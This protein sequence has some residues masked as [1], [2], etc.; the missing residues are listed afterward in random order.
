[1]ARA[2]S[3]ARESLDM[4]K[5]HSAGQAWKIWMAEVHVAVLCRLQGKDAE[6]EA[7][8][9]E[10]R[11]IAPKPGSPRY[12][13]TA[14]SCERAAAWLTKLGRHD[15]A[16]PLFAQSQSIRE[17]LDAKHWTCSDVKS[18]R[19]RSLDAQGRRAEAE[20]LLVESADRLAADPAAPA[21]RVR[22]AREAVVSLYEGWHAAEP[23]K[24][25]DA[26]AS[27]HRARLAGA[28]VAAPR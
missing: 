16:E 5:A 9:A 10:A 23:G 24:G 28:P 22:V 8:E 11:E 26:K 18:A 17:A 1:M 27:A 21:E 19:G 15:L 6:A 12:A 4:H 20:P 14:V 2:E 7:L 25:Y 13:G 3:L